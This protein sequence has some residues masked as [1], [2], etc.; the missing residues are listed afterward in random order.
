MKRPNFDQLFWIIMG[1][2]VFLMITNIG[3][4]LRVNQLQ[5]II[6][7]QMNE[8]KGLQKGIIAPEFNLPDLQGKMVSIEDFKGQQVL[9]MF[10]QVR[11]KYCLEMYPQLKEFQAKYPEITILMISSGTKEENRILVEEHQFS[12]PVL[13]ESGELVPVY[14]VPSTPF[15]YLID[16]DGFIASAGIANS[17]KELEKLVKAS[18]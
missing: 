9:M 10:S 13:I 18:S 2:V 3:L 16:K 15:F 7:S 11:C 14:Q 12:F 17:L 1:L 6:L 4:F 5:E 8:P